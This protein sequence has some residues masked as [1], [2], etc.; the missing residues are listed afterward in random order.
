MIWSELIQSA[1]SLFISGVVQSGG[2]K[3]YV[4]LYGKQGVQQLQL[5]HEYNNIYIQYIF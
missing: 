3:N 2:D 5:L 1:S 4:I